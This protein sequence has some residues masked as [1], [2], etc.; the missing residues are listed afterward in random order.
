MEKCSDNFVN[1]PA[2]LKFPDFLLQNIQLFNHMFFS[3][4]EKKS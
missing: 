2:S 3:E 1:L 4:N